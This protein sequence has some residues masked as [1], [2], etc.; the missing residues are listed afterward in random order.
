MQELIT[1]ATIARPVRADRV[2]ACADAGRRKMRGGGSAVP[3]ELRQTRSTGGRSTVD[4]STWIREGTVKFQ[5]TIYE[6]LE[7]TPEAFLGR[8]KGENS[9]KAIVTLA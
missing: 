8:F 2:R 5:E 1:N 6:G 3:K 7:R 4:M 9:G